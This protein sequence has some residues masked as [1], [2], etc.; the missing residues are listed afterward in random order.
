MRRDVNLHSRLKYGAKTRTHVFAN[1]R[2]LALVNEV[3]EGDAQHSTQASIVYRYDGVVELRPVEEFLSEGI[4][5][6]EPDG[7]GLDTS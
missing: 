5:A 2:R 4:I 7:D 6:I 3:R 1:I